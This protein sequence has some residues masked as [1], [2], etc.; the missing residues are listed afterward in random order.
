MRESLAC[1]GSSG[2]LSRR[3]WLPPR[4]GTGSAHWQPQC[5]RAAPGPGRTPGPHGPGP[6]SDSEPADSE[7]DR[8]GRILLGARPAEPLS[9][10][11]RWRPLRR[12]CHCQPES[13][14]SRRSPWH[15][16]GH[17]G[18][19]IVRVKFSRRPGPARARGPPPPGPGQRRHAQVTGRCLARSKLCV[20]TSCD[21][22]VR[23]DT[24]FPPGPIFL[25][26]NP[27]FFFSF[28]FCAFISAGNARQ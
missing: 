4:P 15:G 20:S 25:I 16:H 12:G 8:D 6:D 18:T 24:P 11:Q 26:P 23:P 19:V 28:S 22:T 5:G 14:R 3:L 9:R 13:R 1:G 2:P 21:S 10:P 7:S 27:D 17:G